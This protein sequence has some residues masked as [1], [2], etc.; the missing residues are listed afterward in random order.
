VWSKS[1]DGWVVEATG[2]LGDGRK[3]RSTT[4]YEP[5]DKDRFLWK[6]TAA[7]TNGQPVADRAIEMIRKALD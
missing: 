6:T 3:T 4:L 2:V 5:G 1:G 7:R